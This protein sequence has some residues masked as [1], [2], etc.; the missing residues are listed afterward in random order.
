MFVGYFAG[1]GL[2]LLSM[3][4]PMQVRVG[5]ENKQACQ[6]TISYKSSLQVVYY[7]KMLNSGIS[8]K[9]YALIRYHYKQFDIPFVLSSLFVRRRITAKVTAT[10]FS[11]TAWPKRIEIGKRTLDNPQPHFTSYLRE[12]T[13][14]GVLQQRKLFGWKLFEDSD[15][16][17]GEVM[18]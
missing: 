16:V 10:L 1:L 4:K 15:S 5:K 18:I 6:G 7:V 12:L 2:L 13:D 14:R 11:G 17:D 9:T 8:L 3:L